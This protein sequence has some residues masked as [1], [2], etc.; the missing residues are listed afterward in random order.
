[1]EANYTEV[2]KKI[3][4]DPNLKKFCPEYEKLFQ[5][6]FTEISII[7]VKNAYKSFEK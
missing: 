7:S 5:V 2:L 3:A 1:M 4:T 6:F